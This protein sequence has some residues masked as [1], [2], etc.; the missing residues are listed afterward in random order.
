M[1]YVILGIFAVML[2]GM[3]IWLRRSSV[4]YDIGSPDR[5][6]RLRARFLLGGVLAGIVLFP[7]LGVVGWVFGEEWLYYERVEARVLGRERVCVVEALA[8]RKGRDRW[9]EQTDPIPCQEA[10]VRV[11]QFGEGARV[12]NRDKVAFR[13]VDPAAGGERDG[14]FIYEFSPSP[15]AQDQRI[16]VLVLKSGE[17]PGRRPK[18]LQ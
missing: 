12:A 13:Y 15:F 1:I 6:Q 8:R 5:K 18:S 4:M 2:I 3:V 9:R 11:A 14:Y 10:L 16:S 7:I 17:G